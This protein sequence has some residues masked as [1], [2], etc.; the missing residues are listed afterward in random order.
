MNDEPNLTDDR[1]L[2]RVFVREGSDRA[3]ALLV[4]RH[5]SAV[6]SAA[7][8]RVNGERALA[9]DITQQVFADLARKARSL[10]ESVVIGGWLHRHTGFV[11]LKCVDRERRRRTREQ[12]AAAMTATTHADPLWHQT[13]PL[14]DEALDH[15]PAGDRD[16]L[17]LRFFEKRDLR[18]VGSALGVSDDTA[19]K[20]VARALE[21]LRVWLG[22][23]G[24]TS[25][26]GALAVV[27]SAEAVRAA[28]LALGTVVAGSA[29]A[30]AAAGGGRESLWELMTRATRWKL[31]AGGALVAGALAWQ[32]VEIQRL[33]QAAAAGTA[34]SAGAPAAVTP[35][36]GPVPEASGAIASAASATD[37]DADAIAEAARIL[38]G[39]AQD[40]SS[41]TQALG[42]LGRID[43]RRIPEALQAVSRVDDEAAQA[44]IYKYLI[45]R[46]AEA[47]PWQ[48]LRYVQETLPLQ[49][50]TGVFEGVLTAWAGNDPESALAWFEKSRGSAPPPLRESLLATIFRGLGTRD[51]GAATAQLS[52][53]RT[54]NERGQALRGLLEAVRTDDQRGLLLRKAESIEDEEARRQVRRAVVE[55]WVQQDA[56]AA[57]A[58]VETAEPAHERVGLMD[59]LGLAWL[60]TEPARAAD[61]WVTHA[62]GPQTLIKIMNV[63]AHND[64][65]AAGEWLGRLPAG[66][67]SDPARMT[68]ARQVSDLDPESALRWAETI[69]E[70]ALRESTIDHVFGAWRAR[71]GAAAQSF[72]QKATWPEERVARL[73]P[74]VASTPN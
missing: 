28:P 7:L 44:L 11:A 69:S 12:E 56:A 25:T 24:V 5:V 57:A 73:A 66:P 64:P 45:G 74:P 6:F 67:E 65:N 41:T 37:A 33:R 49:C 20:R 55:H 58:F 72:L 15:L 26:A 48:A 71:D 8:R 19:Q 2:L 1:E 4:G 32:Q 3:F 23:R 17:V 36:P 27:L 54:E 16:A 42:V 14:L 29:L 68:F 51:L 70:A 62:P 52:W 13:A 34:A 10:P 30:T 59:S 31:A 61:W 50:R 43:G 39:G 46:W 18:E 53:L 21:K 63:W 35:A 47:E 38:R 40:V 22:R 60:Q 9:E